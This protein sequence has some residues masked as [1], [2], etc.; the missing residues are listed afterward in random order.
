MTINN[1]S[2]LTIAY[3]GRA[4]WKHYLLGWFICTGIVLTA[5]LPFVVVDAVRL[6][7]PLDELNLEQV[8]Q[9]NLQR[10]LLFSNIQAIGS[11]IGLY[12][13]V[14]RLHRRA[15]LSLIS[16]DA[17][18]QWRRIACGFW[19]WLG[20]W[21]I[22]IVVL[23]YLQ[24]QQYIWVFN[25]SE[26]WPISLW[27]VISLILSAIA[28]G[29]L[30]AYLFQ[31]IGTV[32]RHP[33]RLTMVLGILGLLSWIVNEP[34]GIGLFVQMTYIWLVIWL[35]LKDDRL[36]LA[37][38][39]WLAWAVINWLVVGQTDLSSQIPGFFKFNDPKSDLIGQIAILIQAIV[40]YLIC[41]GWPSHPFSLTADRK[42][43]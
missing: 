28:N 8:L 39:L 36:E 21:V 33:I 13:I 26:W 42:Q 40:F 23:G 7:I 24:P 37:L 1:C 2:F 6:D 32:I 25:W 30:F 35:T 3:Q 20:P 17:S 38:G 22:S 4:N 15:F 10:T 27:T 11:L 19:A 16:A 14:N 12:V 34:S 29:F 18:I 31:A 5:M 41:F 9:G 43:A